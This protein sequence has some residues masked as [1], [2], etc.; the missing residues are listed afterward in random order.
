MI[1]ID[2][3]SA[4]SI[5]LSV[6]L[7]IVFVVWIFYNFQGAVGKTPPGLAGQVHQCPY[8]TQ[9]FT[10]EAYDEVL[11]CPRCRSYIDEANTGIGPKDAAPVKDQ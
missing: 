1:P 5:F 9:V 4:I 2:I 11:R 3:V 6:C 7:G 10:N 8:C